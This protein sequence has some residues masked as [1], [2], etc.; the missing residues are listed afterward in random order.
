MKFPKKVWDKKNTHTY[1]HI[2]SFISCLDRK[3]G[4]CRDRGPTYRYWVVGRARGH[5]VVRGQVNTN[6]GI[7]VNGSWK[8]SS[9]KELKM[10]SKEKYLLG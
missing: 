4:C 6:E 5:Q 8:K 3:H 2:Y 7:Q 10:L 9:Y 1:I